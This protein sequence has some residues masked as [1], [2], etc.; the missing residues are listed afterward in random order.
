MAPQVENGYTRIANE[1]LE[2]LARI[3]VPGEAA[4]ILWVII[5][6]TYG[7]GRKM[8][9]IA[10]SQFS[11][12]TGLSA[13]HVLRAIYRLQDLGMI[14][15]DGSGVTASYGIN[16]HY[17]EWTPTPKKISHAAKKKALQPFCYICGFDKAIED[18]HITPRSQGGTNKLENRINLC[19]NCHTLAHKGNFTR[20]ELITK[21]GNIEN[22][23]TEK[24]NGAE[25]ITENGNEKT[26]NGNE[27]LP[28]TVDTKERVKKVSKETTAGTTASAETLT[29]TFEEKEGR[30]KELYP[31][32]QFEIEKEKCIAWYSK[33]S[34]PAEPWV[35]ILKWFQRIAT[36]PDPFKRDDRPGEERYAHLLNKGEDEQ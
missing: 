8:D 6:Q 30:L 33:R 5:R 21:K 23:I 18:H 35:T 28:K 31:T 10:I 16:K 19:P 7:Y 29:K 26:K 22:T 15:K 36:P 13:P 24:G 11:E 3:R 4:Q 32:A 12:K 20:E 17:Q 27:P 9:R 1:L 25:T 34:L 2:A 14:V